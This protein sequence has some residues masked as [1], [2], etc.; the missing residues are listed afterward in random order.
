MR[1]ASVPAALLI[2]P[3]LFEGSKEFKTAAVDIDGAKKLLAEAGYPDGFTTR[4]DWTMGGG[5]DVNTKAEAEWI[6]RSFGAR[7]R[8]CSRTDVGTAPRRRMSA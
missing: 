3:L 6:H 1:G 2:S 4:L 5:G 8:T 7:A